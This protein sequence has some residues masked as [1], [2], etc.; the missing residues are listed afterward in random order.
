MRLVAVLLIFLSSLSSAVF[1]QDI[2]LPQSFYKNAYLSNTTNQV[3]KSFYPLID[4]NY[5]QSAFVNDSTVFYYDFFVWFFNRNWIEI[6]EKAGTL[7][8]SP[9]INLSVGRGFQNADSNLL[10]RNT[11]GIS[12]NGNFG[13]KV[14]Y[15]FVL[16]ENQSRFLDYQN[17]YFNDRGEFYDND[18][19]F[20]K[21]NAVIP[22]G[23]R[24][25]PFKT[26]GYDYAFSYG[27]INYLLTKKIGLEGGNNQQF[28]G[29]GYRS[30]LLSDNSIYAPYLKFNWS[31]GKKI[32]Y[33]LLW[34]KH[35]NLYRKPVTTAVESAYEPKFFSAIYLSYQINKR[36]AVSLFSSSN[37]LRADSN[38]VHPF[39]WQSLS[40]IPLL[41]ND[42]LLKNT[43]INGISGINLDF[44]LKNVK[45]YAQF[46]IDEVGASKE[47]AFQLGLFYGKVMNFGNFNVR[48][49]FNHVSP[50]FYS[51]KN[52]KLSYSQYNL[53]LAHPKG[54]NF[55]E[56]ILQSSY[57][58]KRF[59]I[60]LSC[61]Y[62][63]TS[64]GNMQD[65]IAANSIFFQ[66]G[67][68]LGGKTLSNYLEVGYR[69]NKKYNPT[70]YIQHH[71]RNSSFGNEKLSN[72]A[73][74]AGLKVSLFNQYL[75]F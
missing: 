54:N 24:T 13:R 35:R 46:A 9:L 7:N 40:P 44:A 66:S 41:N 14:F 18:S 53:P 16:C 19:I 64:G 5:N 68:F 57:S 51:D 1:S 26:N 32:S 2:V 10:Y 31:I 58:V 49:E 72:Q 25:K 45:F 3:N 4:S 60:E 67:G 62:Y 43:L 21:V 22:S 20:Q 12:A 36:L 28:I 63:Q 33:H 69:I 59:Y 71:L 8:I 65:Q 15:Q 17:Q 73:L 55:S 11:R 6:K 23:A 52:D 47:T 37:A 29:N 61:I 42:I 74:L 70:L 27:S 34:R 30:L 56:F 50:G 38:I 39:Q 48:A 75:D